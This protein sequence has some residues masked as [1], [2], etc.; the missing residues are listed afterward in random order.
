MP[1]EGLR[2]VPP[3][4]EAVEQAFL[5]AAMTACHDEAEATLARVE[6]DTLYSL[7]HQDA[8]RAIK[9]LHARGDT[10]DAV[11][12]AA[13][14]DQAKHPDAIVRVST[15]F[16][17]PTYIAKMDQYAEELLRLARVRQMRDACQAYIYVTGDDWRDAKALPDLQTQAENVAM[18][19]VCPPTPEE[20]Y[21]AYIERLEQKIE[22]RATTGLAGI[23]T[24]FRVLDE[25]IGGW[26]EG[27]YF[28]TGWSNLGKSSLIV[29]HVLAAARAGYRVRVESLDMPYDEFIDRAV[30]RQHSEI[31]SD[32]IMLGDLDERAMDLVKETVAWLA[33]RQVAFAHSAHS[34]ESLEATAARYHETFDLWIIENLQN[35]EI[36]K[37]F[38]AQSAYD[39]MVYVL[40]R[41]KLLKTKYRLPILVGCQA[42]DP[43]DS[44]EASKAN[45]R[46]RYPSMFDLEGARKITQDAM[47]VI[48]P[49]RSG[50]PNAEQDGDTASIIL[51][52]HQRSRHSGRKIT[53]EWD[54]RTGQYVEPEAEQG[55]LEF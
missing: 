19:E 52:K 6:C 27:L 28:V 44:K 51:L 17:G 13:K 32:Q 23:P 18:A 37:K 42:K 48:A 40:N 8:L 26:S 47:A 4:N 36:E 55:R 54:E 14:L 50:Y 10:A 49:W 9:E 16:E 12:V 41:L 21:E 29:S 5:R 35:I 34:I 1:D 46:C 31:A 38:R 15:L 39:R 25:L 7:F 11:S 22:A 33:G 3:H 43:P 45:Y 53:V 2:Q 24:G 30:I 20:C